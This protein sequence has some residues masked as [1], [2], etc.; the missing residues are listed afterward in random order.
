MFVCVC[1]IIYYNVVLSYSTS[2]PNDTQNI[3]RGDLKRHSHSVIS[4][5]EPNRRSITHTP[6]PL[7]GNYLIKST[8]RFSNTTHK[9]VTVKSVIIIRILFHVRHSETQPRYAI[10]LKKKLAG[11]VP[12]NSACPS[13]Y[14]REFKMNAVKTDN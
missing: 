3:A 13:M 9:K 1:I 11:S 7:S 12:E 5:F 2:L 8:Y 10:K 14:V 4:K 6:I